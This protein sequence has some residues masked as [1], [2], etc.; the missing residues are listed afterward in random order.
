MR[1]TTLTLFIVFLLSLVSCSSGSP[2]AFQSVQNVADCD[3]FI[4]NKHFSSKAEVGVDGGLAMDYNF[5]DQGNIISFK[6]VFATPSG[7][8]Y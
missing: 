5:S 8:K 7:S 6:P 2:E 1:K 4:N 3:A